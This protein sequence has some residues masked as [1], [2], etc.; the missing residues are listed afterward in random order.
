MI[1]VRSQAL[2]PQLALELGQCGEQV[3]LQAPRGRR[4][5]DLLVEARRPPR[6][7]SGNGGDRAGGGQRN[8]ASPAAVSQY[9]PFDPQV[10]IVDAH[11]VVVF[12]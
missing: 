6:A 5:V 11:G 8:A 7:R 4:R 2:G 3:D 9:S 10:L 12:D 1:G